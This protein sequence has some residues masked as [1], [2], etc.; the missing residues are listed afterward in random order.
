[1]MHNDTSEWFLVKY[2][3]IKTVKIFLK[4]L[5]MLKSSKNSCFWTQCV[6]RA[7]PLC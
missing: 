1:M 5:K 2:A 4:T 7:S 3:M 6:E